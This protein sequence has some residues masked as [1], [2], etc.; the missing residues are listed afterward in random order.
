[1][2]VLFVYM[3]I[4]GF[5]FMFSLSMFGNLMKGHYEKQRQHYLT[6]QKQQ[7]QQQKE[8]GDSDSDEQD[9]S[10]VMGEE[11]YVVRNAKN[12]SAV[13]HDDDETDDGWRSA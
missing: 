9:Y 11:R 6:N 10:D 8:S 7:E 2:T 3:V 5:L 12:S 1:M 13:V 4:C